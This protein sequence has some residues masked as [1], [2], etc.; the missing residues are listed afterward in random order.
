MLVITIRASPSFFV[1]CLLLHMLVQW[2][3]TYAVS[4]SGVSLPRPIATGPCMP[5]MHHIFLAKTASRN[6]RFSGHPV[7]Y[8]SAFGMADVPRVDIW[9]AWGRWQQTLMWLQAKYRRQVLRTDCG[10]QTIAGCS[11]CCQR[12]TIAAC[13]CLLCCYSRQ[14]LVLVRLRLLQFKQIVVLAAIFPRLSPA[15]N[16]RTA[17]LS[18]CRNIHSKC[19]EKFDQVI[20]PN[21]VVFILGDFNPR[22]ERDEPLHDI[23]NGV[24]QCKPLLSFP[25]R[26]ISLIMTTFSVMSNTVMY[27]L[28]L[29]AGSLTLILVKKLTESHGLW[30]SVWFTKKCSSL[31]LTDLELLCRRISCRLSNCQVLPDQLI[32]FITS[33]EE[34]DHKYSWLLHMWAYISIGY[35]CVQKLE[36]MS[37]LQDRL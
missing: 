14:R 23:R 35:T 16:S 37:M 7:L 34:L 19:D 21:S 6:T 29:E 9:Q 32:S 30:L 17:W 31:I 10:R 15:V 12:P 11:H 8:V 3:I 33:I 4:F 28:C 22:R 13:F 27:S 5:T 26:T 24:R 36:N 25:F 20:A 18:I 2:Y 1:P